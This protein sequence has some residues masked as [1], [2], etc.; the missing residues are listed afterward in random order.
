MSS[1][2]PPLACLRARGPSNHQ[3]YST[4]HIRVYRKWTIIL[5]T[6]SSNMYSCHLLDTSFKQINFSWL[7]LYLSHIKQLPFLSR[8]P[9]WIQVWCLFSDDLEF[10]SFVSLSDARYLHNVLFTVWRW[11]K[12]KGLHKSAKNN[13]RVIGVTSRLTNM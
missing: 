9:L 7:I 4:K 1:Y 12:G 13:N 8:L 2:N 11:D 3:P 10:F 5:W 6:Q